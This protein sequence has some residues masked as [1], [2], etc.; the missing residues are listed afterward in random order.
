ML[1]LTIDPE[2]IVLEP[3][4]LS[5]ALSQSE[6]MRTAARKIKPFPGRINRRTT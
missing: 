1:K 5:P 2:R 3:D 6:M 4:P